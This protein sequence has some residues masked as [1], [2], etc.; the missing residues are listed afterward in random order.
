MYF[1]I[2]F[3]FYF[4]V[5]NSVLFSC[6]GVWYFHQIS[7]GRKADRK[8]HILYNFFL[9][10][11]WAVT[12]ELVGISILNIVVVNT[13]DNIKRHYGIRK[14]YMM[15][16]LMVFIWLQYFFLVSKSII[17]LKYLEIVT[18]CLQFFLLLH[19]SQEQLQQFEFFLKK[20]MCSKKL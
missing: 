17:E 19:V 18:N 2:F 12:L 16:D 8:P 6:V 4:F 7:Y 11:S 14:S 3:L 10:T 13:V 5:L 15:S 1:F 20:I 9:C